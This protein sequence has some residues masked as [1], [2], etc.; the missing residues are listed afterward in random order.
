MNLLVVMI[1]EER[2]LEKVLTIL[3]EAEACAISV[4]NGQGLWG[5]AGFEPTP[6]ATVSPTPVPR[7]AVIKTIFSILIDESMMQKIKELLMEENIDFALPD[8]GVMF[9]VPIKEMVSS[10]YFQCK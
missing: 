10:T 9:T 2:Y 3:V 8:V 1:N 4:H 5:D 7:K 6:F